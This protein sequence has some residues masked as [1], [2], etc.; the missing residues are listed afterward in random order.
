MSQDKK[1][2][3]VDHRAFKFRLDPTDA[4][5]SLL[6]QS[7][8]AARVG[9]NMLLGHNM[10]AYQARQELHASL[11]DSGHSEHTTPHAP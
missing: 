3:S 2:E 4:Q 6:A 7:A 8:G 11:L 9:Y 1:D 5:L 10:A